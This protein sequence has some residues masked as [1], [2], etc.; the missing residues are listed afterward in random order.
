MNKEIYEALKKILEFLEIEAEKSKKINC[1]IGDEIKQVKSW[2]D[3][4]T[5]NYE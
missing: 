1:F 2:T 3:K 4:T 5:K